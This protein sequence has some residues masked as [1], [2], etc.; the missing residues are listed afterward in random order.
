L[1]DLEMS[2]SRWVTKF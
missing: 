2:R 1:N